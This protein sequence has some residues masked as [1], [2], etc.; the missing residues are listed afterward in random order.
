MCQSLSVQ[1]LL[2]YYSKETTGVDLLEKEKFTDQWIETENLEIY[3]KLF[4]TCICQSCK[5]FNG[6]IQQ[7][8]LEQFDVYNPIKVS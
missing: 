6:K 8:L 3:L 2:R 4:P 1:N 5:S 7:F